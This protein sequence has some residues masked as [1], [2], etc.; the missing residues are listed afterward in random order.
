MAV[1]IKIKR[2][3]A[4]EFADYGSYPLELGEL[5]YATDTHDL[6]VGT[7][8]ANENLSASSGITASEHR[9]LDQ[10]VHNIA[11]DAYEEIVR[12]SGKVT[13]VIYWTDSGKTTKIRETLITRSSGKVSQIVIKQYNAGGSLAETL[14]GTFART[15]GKVSSIT[16]SLT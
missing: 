14:T 9:L 15:D 2:G 10:L 11:E 7:G 4:A 13:S 5:G 6:Y 12:T 16:W 1:K 8:L 3:L